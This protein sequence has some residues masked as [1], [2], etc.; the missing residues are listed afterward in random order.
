MMFDKHVNLKYKYG[1]RY[2]LCRVY[3]VDTLRRK[4][5]AIKECICNQL[6][7]DLA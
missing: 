4:E 7:E 6:Q 5:G 1:N 3:Y 2:F